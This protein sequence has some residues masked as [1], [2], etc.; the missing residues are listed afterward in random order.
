MPTATKPS[1]AK[2]RLGRKSVRAKLTTD[3][4]R[5]QLEFGEPAEMK[6]GQV[7]EVVLD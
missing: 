4:Q 2:V 1:K 5:A 3:G 7:L 6:A